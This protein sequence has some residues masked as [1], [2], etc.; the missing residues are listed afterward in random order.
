MTIN[1]IA[2]IFIYSLVIFVIAKVLIAWLHGEIKTDVAWEWF[3]RGF[4]MSC[5]FMACFFVVLFIV[6]IST[7]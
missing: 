4:F 7:N 1:D 2:I 3:L 6:K 5:G